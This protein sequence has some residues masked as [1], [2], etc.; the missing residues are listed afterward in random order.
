MSFLIHNGAPGVSAFRTFDGQITDVPASGW[1]S[2]SQPVPSTKPIVP[3]SGQVIL[4]LVLGC[5]TLPV[6]VNRVQLSGLNAFL[7]TPSLESYKSF[8]FSMH[9]F[10][11]LVDIALDSPIEPT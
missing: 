8:G 2:S 10:F 11:P 1:R 5:T 3:D 6:S 4:H 7:I 9:Y